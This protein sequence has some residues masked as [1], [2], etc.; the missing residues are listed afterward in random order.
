VERGLARRPG[1]RALTEMR[2]QLHA[3]KR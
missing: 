2:D 3:A 1:D